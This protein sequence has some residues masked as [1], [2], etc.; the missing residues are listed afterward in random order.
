MG[1]AVAGLRSS[2]GGGKKKRQTFKSTFRKGG[3]K[4]KPQK[5]KRW[6]IVL[7]VGAVALEDRLV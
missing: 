4:N 1:T 5:E 7:E 2:M 6:G 3:G